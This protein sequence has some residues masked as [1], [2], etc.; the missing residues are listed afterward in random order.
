MS[1]EL[2]EMQGPY[3]LDPDTVNKEIT[4]KKEGNYALGELDVEDE[5]MFTYVGRSDSD[6]RKRIKDH[7]GEGYTH[8]MFSYATSPKEAFE[9]E[10]KNYHDFKD[11]LCHNEKHPDCPDNSK[12]LKCPRCGT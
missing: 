6:V 4:Q 12:D 5:F 7:F 1:A 8:F 11:R 9:K 2:L 10:C 3:E